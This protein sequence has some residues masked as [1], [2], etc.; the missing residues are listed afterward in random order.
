MIPN[1]IEGA[2][3][4]LGAP[5]NWRWEDG[6]CDHLAIRDEQLDGQTPAM[7]S[8]WEPSPEELQKLNEGKPVY[9]QVLGSRHPPVFV[10]V[11]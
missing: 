4:Y 8:S 5:P 3:R 2:T 9:L 11:P 10:W 7:I 6:T 1:R